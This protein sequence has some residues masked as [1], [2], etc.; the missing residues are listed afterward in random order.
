MVDLPQQTNYALAVAAA[1]EKLRA[2]PVE[3]C[4]K[5]GAEALDDGRLKLPVLNAVFIVGPFAGMVALSGGDEVRVGWAVLALHYLASPVEGMR[6]E[7][8]ISFAQ[9]PDGRGYAT[10][11]RGR[12]IERF[13]HTAG[14]T[15]EGFRTASQGLGGQPVDL[16]DAAFRFDVFPRFPITV[17]WHAGDDE[18]PPGAGVLYVPD[19]AERFSAEDIVVMSELLIGKLTGKGW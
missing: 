7:P 15:E 13:L 14:R 6:G 2:V 1:A 3:D 5:L 9:I 8:A 12:V 17:V 10:P 18:L 16:G 11:Y 4:A 19:A